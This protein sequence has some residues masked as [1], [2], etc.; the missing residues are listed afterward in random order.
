MD[1][2]ALH[3]AVRTAVRDGAEAASV[4]GVEGKALRGWQRRVRT[5]PGDIAK[6]V[7]TAPAREWYAQPQ[8]IAD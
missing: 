7:P 4:P 6:V 1:L 8:P 2:S 3:V 5:M